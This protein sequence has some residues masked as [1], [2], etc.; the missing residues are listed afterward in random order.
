MNLTSLWGKKTEW[1]TVSFFFL[2][3]QNIEFIAPSNLLILRLAKIWD[4]QNVNI[5]WALSGISVTHPPVNVT[6]LI[7]Y[8]LYLQPPVVLKSLI[9]Y[10][11]LL[12][13]SSLPHWAPNVAVHWNQ[14]GMFNKKY[15][16]LA[17]NSR[18]SD[19]NGMEFNLST[20]ALKGSSCDSNE[21]QSL[22]SI[23]FSS[24]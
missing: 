11:C 20:G 23:A 2:D 10:P 15:W 14:L 19:L 1:A 22:D 3:P 18:H 21:D 24:F 17:P 7:T 4:S 12:R 16:F 6:F 5:L 13:F 9:I 8:H